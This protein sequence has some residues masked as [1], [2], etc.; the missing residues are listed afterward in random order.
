MARGKLFYYI[1][2]C[3]TC[4][5]TI[6]DPPSLQYGLQYAIVDLRS[7]QYNLRYTVYRIVYPTHPTPSLTQPPPAV[8]PA[9]YTVLTCSTTRMGSEGGGPSKVLWMKGASQ[10]VCGGVNNEEFVMMGL[11]M[12]G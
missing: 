12:R 5:Y 6:T 9:W 8:R 2:A 3:T 11:V 7:L 10:A 4:K 1:T